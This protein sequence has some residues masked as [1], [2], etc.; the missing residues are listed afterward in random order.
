MILK[1]GIKIAKKGKSIDSTDPQDFLLN[2]EL[3]GSVVIYKDA[4]VSVTVP[5]N[6]TV[7]NTQNYYDPTGVHQITFD[8]IPIILIYVELT[9]GS[10]EWFLSPFTFGVDNNDPEDSYIISEEVVGEEYVQQSGVSV[11]NFFL[12]LHNKTAS[13]KV[14]KYHYYIFANL[15]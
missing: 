15:G 4:E 10:N 8:F 5:A 1:R 14:I 12:S 2:T 13:Q 3:D 6:S 7:K 9:S 11:D